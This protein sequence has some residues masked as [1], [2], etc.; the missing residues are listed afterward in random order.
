[1]CVRH[2]NRVTPCRRHAL[3]TLVS[4][5]TRTRACA[6]EYGK[7]GGDGWDGTTCCEGL[8]C[9]RKDDYYSQCAIGPYQ[10]AI[11]DAKNGQTHHQTATVR[12][13]LAGRSSTTWADTH[14]TAIA[15]LEESRQGWL[16][17]RCIGQLAV[18]HPEERSVVL[19]RN[20]GGGTSECC[21]MHPVAAPARTDGAS[22]V[23]LMLEPRSDANRAS[24]FSRNGARV[25][26]AQA[27]VA[28]ASDTPQ[29]ECR[30]GVDYTQYSAWH[31]LDQTLAFTIDLSSTECGCLAAVYLV[32]MH[33]NAAPGNCG[34]D[35]C[36][37]SKHRT[38]HHD[39][40]SA[41]SVRA[42]V[43]SVC[44]L[45]LACAAAVWADCDANSVCGVACS[46]IDLFEGN[47]HALHVT[48]CVR[49]TRP[50]EVSLLA[51]RHLRSTPN[52]LRQHNS[53]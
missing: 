9:R 17:H 39:G 45:S 25:Y 24:W 29:S 3:C 13:A 27:D 8:V 10:Q 23:Q 7:C 5:F 19:V 34:A 28:A 20:P 52:L 35:H 14:R 44:F 18:S 31:L 32:S 2:H 6:L 48:A 42:H 12:M 40:G 50:R 21:H 41:L 38:R 51:P 30:G 16:H 43:V 33:Q 1:M 36:S 22:A 15:K 53:A 46:E 26:F 49:C 37:L 4:L 47:R 11:R